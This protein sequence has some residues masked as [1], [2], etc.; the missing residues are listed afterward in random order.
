VRIGI[1]VRVADPAEPGQQR[2]LW[3]LGGWLGAG[4]HDVHY[5]TVRA[6]PAD[7]ET[8][9]STRLHRL[10]GVSRG[11][12]RAA[13]A[14]LELDALLL[15]PERSRRYRGIQ[16]NVLRAAYGTEQYRQKL[17]SFRSPLERS[18]RAAWR[19]APWTRAELSW[20]RALYEGRTP[21]PDVIA[22]SRYMRGQ[23]LDS[24]RIPPD[25]V[26]IVHNA[27]DT[28]EYAPAARL[29][30]RA[31][32]RRRWGV[33]EDALCLLFLGHNFRLKGLWQM[34]DVLPSVGDLGRPVHL[35]VAGRGTGSGQRRKAE[36][37]VRAARLE[38]RV[39]FAGG[40]RPAL[41]ALAAADALLHLSWHDSF[42]FVTL[43]AMASGLP[44]VT[45]R[46]VGA[47][48]LIDDGV[49][50]LLVDPAENGQ[51]VEAIRALADEKRREALGARAAE[52]GARHDEPDNF[53]QVLD[54][55]RTAV[56]RGY[57]T[58]R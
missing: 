43:E 45:T 12:L 9:P 20:E 44:V 40:V 37:L 18:L 34:L 53:R 22:Q 51:V 32:M 47:A 14:D 10:D 41:H 19:G 23:I 55:L 4:S 28:D 6:Q 21:P 36:R 57:G 13:V 29:A 27:V 26:H 31:E 50:G 38:G 52:V 17:R 15:N 33:P 5:L 25:H 39:T 58:V 2:Y 11:R 24:Y 30:L 16:A 42:G 1:D 56:D 54:V 7:V 46:W 35:L 48:E 49:S 8:P 3:R